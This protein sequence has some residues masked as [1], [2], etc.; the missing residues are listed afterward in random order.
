MFGSTGHETFT[1]ET[2]E[3]TDRL[4]LRAGEFG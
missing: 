2:K 3:L 1:G 4:S